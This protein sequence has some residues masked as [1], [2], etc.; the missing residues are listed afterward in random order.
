MAV[1]PSNMARTGSK[2][3]QNAFQAIPDV[4]FFDGDENFSAKFSVKKFSF[5]LFWRG[6]GEPMEKWTS[7]SASAS[8]FAP[9]APILRSV[10]PEIAKK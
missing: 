2:L 10:R 8:N 5:S 4:S 6:F 9:D 3:G 7:K 1:Y